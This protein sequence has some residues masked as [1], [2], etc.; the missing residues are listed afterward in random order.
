MSMELKDH[1]SS[2]IYLNCTQ[3]QINKMKAK[4]VLNLY[5]YLFAAFF[6]QLHFDVFGQSNVAPLDSVPSYPRVV[7]DLLADGAQNEMFP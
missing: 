1:R 2:L 4:F 5:V 6:L 7:N 3:H